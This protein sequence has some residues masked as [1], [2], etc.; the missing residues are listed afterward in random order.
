MQS[1][2]VHE[3]VVDGLAAVHL[4]SSACVTPL[5]FSQTTARVAEPVPQA[6]LHVPY[7]PVTHLYVGHARVLQFSE[8]ADFA[9]VHL[10]SATVC[11]LPS[12]FSWHI[13][14]RTR[15]PVPH[16]LLHP[17]HVLST[18]FV[19]QAALLHALLLAG[20]VFKALAMQN[21]SATDV[22][23]VPCVDLHALPVRAW[24]PPPQ[25]VVHVP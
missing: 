2:L 12:L 10:P 14:V 25:V 19:A 8:I 18:H 6:L 13:T 24:V 17:L 4:V 15:W 9:P 5:S 7:V 3:P 11:Q 21:E 20:S 23:V 1:G 16:S 22:I